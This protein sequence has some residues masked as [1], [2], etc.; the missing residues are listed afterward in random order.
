MEITIKVRKNAKI[1]N[2]KSS[3]TPDPGLRIGKWKN[4]KDVIYRSAKRSA[5]FQQVTTRLQDNYKRNDP[6]RRNAF[7]QPERILLEGL[8]EFH[9]TT[10]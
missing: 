7:E 4:T 10:S 6:Q 5:L 8:N 1:R 9:S 2:I 3:I